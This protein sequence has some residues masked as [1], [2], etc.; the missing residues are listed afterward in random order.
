MIKVLMFL[1]KYKILKDPINLSYHTKEFFNLSNNAQKRVL[2][3]YFNKLDNN[4]DIA[5]YFIDANSRYY[6]DNKEITF[7][8]S[9]YFDKLLIE[10][11]INNLIY[12]DKFKISNDKIEYLIKYSIEL[13]TKEK[14]KFNIK[15]II[16]YPDKLP[17]KLSNNY[18]FMNYLI[19]ENYYNV[20]YLT[21]NEDYPN[22][23][24]ELVN[25]AISI[26]DSNKYNINLFLK[27]DKTLP[28]ILSNNINFVNYLIK[29]DL[30]NIKYL[31]DK[32]LA[33]T[34]VTSKGIIINTI[35]SSLKKDSSKITII[36]N[37]PHISSILNKNINYIKYIINDDISNMMY[38][39]WHNIT[40]KE[41]ESI[42]D[43]IVVLL[44]KQD[45]MINI[46]KYPFK[47]ILLE[48][49][50]FMTY[51]IEDTP[52]YIALS[53]VASISYTE[54]LVQLFFK[55]IEIKKYKFNL[56][57]FLNEDG[58]LNHY[59]VENKNMLYYFF[60]QNIP[61]IKYI[62]FFNLNNIFNVVDNI[63]KIIDHKSYEFHNED[64]LINNKYPIALSNHYRFMKFVIDKNF[65]NLSFIDISMIDKKELKRIINYA[66]KMV[67]YIRG[68]NKNLNF[69]IE[70]YFKNAPIYENEYFQECLK[71]L[72]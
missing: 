18:N 6:E 19:K 68:N 29:N 40:D 44:K 26:A 41:R 27:S 21:I 64:F 66:F 24:R 61:V 31:T 63:L 30:D 71:S 10:H 3:K 49:Y 20:K 14:V 32:L 52:K 5:P 59:L 58:Y 34:T 53:Q 60:K 57:D 69:D 51:L 17:N 50:N 25:E 37:N 55:T 65:N 35:I 54:K 62:N 9:Y 28:K 36:N 47:D 7:F 72:K 23:C 2:D 56:K 12:I 13:I 1:W 39:D 15:D 48:N 42:I 45:L 4:D 33:T 8:N 43:D 38:I 11:N 16:I 70:G 67:Y 46:D 22:K